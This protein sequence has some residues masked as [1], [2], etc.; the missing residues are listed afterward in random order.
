M[1]T[2]NWIG[3]EAVVNHHLQVPFHLLKDVPEL[4]CG[5]PGDGNLIVQGDNL[6]ALKA[7]LPYYA[8]QV[9][10]IYIDP[11]YNTGVD[12]RDESGKRI[13]WI[14]ND[15]VNSPAIREWLG[16]VVGAEAEDLSR[17]EKWLCMMFPRLAVLRKFLRQEGVIFASIDETEFATLR[18]LLD[19]VFGAT[20]H[21]GTIVWKNVTDNN[22]TNIAM[23]HEYVLCYARNKQRLPRE[24]KSTNLAVKEKL[25]RIGEEFNT[26]YPKLND[27]QRE[28][29]KWFRENKDYLWPFDRY[30]FIDD[31]GIY[32][33]SQSVHNPGKEGYRYDVIHPKTGKPC[34]EPLMG[35]RFPPETMDDLLARKR[36]LFGEDESKII[37]LK[38]YVKDYRAKLSS[39]FELDGRIGTYEIK[40]LFPDDKRPFDFPKPT[41]L[42]EELVGFTTS[43]DDLILDSFAGSGTTG[44]AVL[45]LNS[46]DQQ[47]RHFILVEMKPT[48]ARNLTAERVRRV[49]AGYRN[50][51]GEMI[52]GLG[53]GFRYCELGEPLFDENGKIRETVSFA[54]LARHV[55]FSETGEP[56]PRER[57]RKSPFLGS[58]RGVGI[59]LLYNGILRD[60]SANGGNVLTRAVLAELPPFDGQKVI[61]CAGCLLGKDRLQAERIIVRQTPYEIKVS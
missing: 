21:L 58:C 19:E 22:P 8:G 20:N 45:K 61:Y 33:G 57:V 7:L 11:P 55:Y 37:E 23:E 42:I 30:K 51:K 52:Q 6:V 14:Y 38:L 53:G 27:R 3:K 49:A 59:Y 35:Y 32:T 17:H 1:P 24:W 56:L 5:E 46:A 18:I 28:Y 25:L 36:V 54:D 60:K 29:T 34:V 4:A 47:R 41:E 13:G 50:A 44:H 48:I 26:K 43:G 12:D 15:N 40:E 2:L 10:C 31:G 16:R 9:K 39:L